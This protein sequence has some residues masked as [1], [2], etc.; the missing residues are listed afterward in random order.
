MPFHQIKYVCQFEFWFKIRLASK[1]R[2][3]KK[4]TTKRRANGELEAS[5]LGTVLLCVRS[6][7]EVLDLSLIWST[8][9][10]T[11]TRMHMQIWKGDYMRCRRMPKLQKLSNKRLIRSYRKVSSS[12]EAY[13]L[14]WTSMVTCTSLKPCTNEKFTTIRRKTLL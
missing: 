14:A 2:L 11:R 4:E 3:G 12:T 10:S 8:Q 7:E 9:L 1:I 6:A 13:P 5:L